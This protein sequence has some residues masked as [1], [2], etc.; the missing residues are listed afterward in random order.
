[1]AGRAGRLGLDE[2]GEAYLLADGKVP[3]THLVGLAR[4]C[5][6]D[7]P[8]AAPRTAADEGFMARALLEAI[9]AGIVLSARSVQ[10][11]VESSLLRTLCGP[12]VATAVAKQALR[13]LCREALL[14][15]WSAER[16]EWELTKLGAA[17][18]QG[19]LEPQDVALL[20]VMRKGLRARGEFDNA[21][22]GYCMPVLYTQVYN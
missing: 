4:G 2:C 8:K 21:E 14:I 6:G 22:A 5:A 18:A 15:S 12:A 1:M 19:F 10:L 16:E 7:A 17:A 13:W 3:E 11:F 20:K 9:A